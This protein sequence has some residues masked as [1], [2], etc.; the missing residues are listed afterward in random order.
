MVTGVVSF[1]VRLM[2]LFASISFS[3]LESIL[4]VIPGMLRSI[5]RNR[6]LPLQME[7]M[8]GSFHLPPMT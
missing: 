1:T 7:L 4:L 2:I 5:S 8:T 3:S 6:V